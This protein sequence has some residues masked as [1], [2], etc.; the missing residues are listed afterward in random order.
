LSSIV[1][2]LVDRIS[3]LDST[4]Y[5][6]LDIGRGQD[7]LNLDGIVSTSGY[8]VEVDEVEMTESVLSPSDGNPDRIGDPDDFLIIRAGGELDARASAQVERGNCD[9]RGRFPVR[10]RIMRGGKCRNDCVLASL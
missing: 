8:R 1:E 5:L 3:A 7:C 9:H 6:Y 4:A 10:A 2:K